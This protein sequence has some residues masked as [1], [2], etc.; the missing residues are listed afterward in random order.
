VIVKNTPLLFLRQV[1]QEISKITW[2][3]RRETVMSTL[4]IFIM[5]TIISLFFV[6]V[7]QFF[8]FAIKLI[9]GLGA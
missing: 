7:D 3:S 5:V 1:R 2:P 8:A 4:M 6:L 9:L